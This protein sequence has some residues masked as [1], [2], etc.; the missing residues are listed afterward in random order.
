[1]PNR[2][3]STERTLK[4]E[5]EKELISWSA[6]A[7]P[8]KR[9]DRQFY[10]TVFAIA[11][12]I[13]LVLFL[14]EGWVPVVLIIS[15]VFLFYIMSTVEPESIVYKVT[16]K[17]VKMADK[18][19]DWNVLGRFWFT[20]RFDNELLIIESFAI[21]GRV[22]LVVDPTKKEDIEREISKFLTQ[23]EIPP[24]YFDNASNWFS[25]HLPGNN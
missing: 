3:N 8:F 19:T 1:M 5:P 11:A 23:E 25:R 18:R 7:R 24:S 15:L 2:D 20:K 6:P 12:I 22:E 10:V 4:D 16:N 21:P 9:R 13:G 14:V 17:G